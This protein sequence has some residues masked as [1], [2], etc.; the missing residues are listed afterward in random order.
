MWHS[1]NKGGCWRGEVWDR[2]KNGEIHVKLLTINIIKNGDDKV[3]GRVALF[4][5]ITDRK[6][7]EDLIGK[8]ANYDSITN[9]PNRQL[10]HERLEQKAKK[11]HRSGRPIARLLIDLG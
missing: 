10:N 11:C 1:L 2:R 5:D 7:Y 6:A 4:T 8:Q 3:F 9:L